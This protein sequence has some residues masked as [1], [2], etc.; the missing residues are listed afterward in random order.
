MRIIETDINDI[1]F[2]NI[3]NEKINLAEEIMSYVIPIFSK[4]YT[5]KIKQIKDLKKDINFKKEKIKSDKLN[6]EELLKKYSKIDKESQLLNK[7][8]K[9]IQTGLVQE[10]MKTEMIVLLKSFENVKEEKIVEY[11]NETISIISKK[12]AKS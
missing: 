7:M 11:L 12:F 9:L 5:K 10:S 8:G 2:S 1:E 4:D 3:N 6:L